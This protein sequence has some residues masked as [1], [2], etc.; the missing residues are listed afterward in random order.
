MT[1]GDTVSA[2][3]RYIPKRRWWVRTWSAYEEALALAED[4]RRDKRY[5]FGRRTRRHRPWP[6]EMLG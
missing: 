6:W 2:S 4:A 1:I 3:G 5:P